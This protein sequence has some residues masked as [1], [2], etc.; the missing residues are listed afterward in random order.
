MVKLIDQFKGLN[1]V[2]IGSGTTV[3]LWNDCFE[4]APIKLQFPELFLFARNKKIFL[5][6]A[7]GTDNIFDMFH[8]P[9]SEEAYQQ[10]QGQQG[11]LQNI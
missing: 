8:L 10:V 6:K 11:M 4:G 2:Q 1:S 5:S 9:L 7:V 3:M